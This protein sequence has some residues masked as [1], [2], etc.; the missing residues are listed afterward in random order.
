MVKED[1]EEETTTDAHEITRCNLT[2][3]FRV[4]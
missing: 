3:N 1:I 2:L 4:N